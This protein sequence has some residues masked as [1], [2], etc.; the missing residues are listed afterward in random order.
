MAEC[1]KKAFIYPTVG[2]FAGESL[3]SMSL[4]GGRWLALS[5]LSTLHYLRAIGFMARIAK[6]IV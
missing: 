1:Q 6:N 5:R 2:K 3:E 4:S